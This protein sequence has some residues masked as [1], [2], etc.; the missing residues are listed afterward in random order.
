MLKKKPVRNSSYM[1]QYVKENVIY[2]P[3][4]ALLHTQPTCMYI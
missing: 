3:E 1:C 4:H 2:F